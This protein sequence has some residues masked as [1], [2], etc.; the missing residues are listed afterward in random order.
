[1]APA[2][3]TTCA[4]PLSTAGHQ[5]QQSSSQPQ[6]CP[7]RMCGWLNEVAAAGEGVVL[8]ARAG[9]HAARPPCPPP[10]PLPASRPCSQALDLLHMLPQRHPFGAVG[11]GQLPGLGDTLGRRG[12]VDVGGGLHVAQG[13]VGRL[14]NRP[15]HGAAT[16]RL[17][18]PG[19]RPVGGEGA[20]G[21]GCLGG[22]VGEVALPSLR[23]GPAC[24]VRQAAGPVALAHSSSY[25]RPSP[26]QLP[27]TSAAATAAP[28]ARSWCSATG[29]PWRP[30]GRHTL[31]CWEGGHIHA[32]RPDHTSTLCR[33]LPHREMMQSRC[34]AG[35]KPKTYRVRAP[36]GARLLAD[37]PRASHC[38]RLHGDPAQAKGNL[39][40]RRRK[41]PHPATR[42]EWGAA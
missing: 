15:L 5:A 31:Q 32:D 10:L 29:A 35:G 2:G 6:K 23:A 11:D 7:Y 8:E 18:A 40:D 19:A 4:H 26:Q 13:R 30:L 17:W 20:R 41:A 16:L 36:P 37:C 24:A 34:Q 27:A 9:V 38:D 14:R 12:V 22:E 33:G 21:R 42:R 3:T 39:V 1:M 28:G 25:R